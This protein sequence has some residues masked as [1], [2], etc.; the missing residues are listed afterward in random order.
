MNKKD[1]HF[2][3]DN[4]KDRINFYYKNKFQDFIHMDFDGEGRDICGT[5]GVGNRDYFLFFDYDKCAIDGI[6]TCVY[7]KA[8]LMDKRRKGDGYVGTNKCS[9]EWRN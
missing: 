8:G 2:E 7:T 3:I 5:F 6:T 9:Q 1:I 4:T